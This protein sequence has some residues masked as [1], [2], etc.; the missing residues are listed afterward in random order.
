MPAEALAAPPPPR[1]ARAAAPAVDLP[2]MDGVTINYGR[3]EEIFG[4]GEPADCLYRVV[5]GAVR[6]FRV[7][8]DGR[9]QIAEFYLSGDL[10][11]LEATTEHR[12]SAEAIT[13]SRIVVVRRRAVMELAARDPAVASRFWALATQGLGRHQD[14]ILTLGRKSPSERL[15]TFLVDC[16][17][18]AGAQDVIDLPMTRQD[19]AD[20]LG[21]T[22]ETVSRTLTQFRGA[23]LISLPSYRRVVLSNL[24]GLM[25]LSA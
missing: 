18:R 23:G 25:R 1:E 2:E 3:D 24:R 9:R 11:G 15:A 10:F 17:H 8:S 6:A 19:I 16:A 5:S 13:E 20:F 14:H 4:E 21:L 12:V 7:L 22:I